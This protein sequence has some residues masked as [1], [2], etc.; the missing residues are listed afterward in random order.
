M[1]SPKLSYALHLLD[2]LHRDL[3]DNAFALER[4]GRID[5]ADVAIATARRVAATGHLLRQRWDLSAAGDPPHH[6]AGASPPALSA[7]R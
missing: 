2:A 1:N 6:A 7:A 5:A 4:Q 3:I